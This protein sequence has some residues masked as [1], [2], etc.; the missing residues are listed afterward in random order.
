MLTLAFIFKFIST[1]WYLILIFPLRTFIN[2]IIL[3]FVG[4]DF[5]YIIEIFNEI[6]YPYIITTI[7]YYKT[8]FNEFKNNLNNLINSLKGSV[9]NIPTKEVE[10]VEEVKPVWNDADIKLMKQM[11]EDFQKTNE[12][13][14]NLNNNDS[15]NPA[16]YVLGACGILFIGIGIYIYFAVDLSVDEAVK[17]ITDSVKDLN[18]DKG[19]GIGDGFAGTTPAIDPSIINNIFQNTTS[20]STAPGTVEGYNIS[21]STPRGGN[22]TLNLTETPFTSTSAVAP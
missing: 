4:L 14:N 10:I 16:W 2:F 6:V 21:P 19:K 15:I 9:E 18:L 22:A 8:I 13:I 12:A 20:T 17:D 1:F 7:E 5:N 11:K 3:L